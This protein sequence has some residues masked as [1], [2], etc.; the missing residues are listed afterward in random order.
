MSTFFYLTT[1]GAVGLLSLCNKLS[2]YFSVLWYKNRRNNVCLA[3]SGLDSPAIVC[4][5]ARIPWGVSRR[6]S[7]LA[8]R[9]NCHMI[10]THF[11]VRHVIGSIDFTIVMHSSDVSEFLLLW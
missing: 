8:L 4:K 7:D 1:L 11:R 9:H 6:C 5:H 3:L 2:K 10:S